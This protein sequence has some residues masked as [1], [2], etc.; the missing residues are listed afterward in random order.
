[1]KATVVVE[2][3]WDAGWCGHLEVTGSPGQD[4]SGTTIGFT[5]PTGTRITQTWNGQFSATEGRVRVGLPSW[6]R[7]PMTATGFCVAGTGAATDV[8]VG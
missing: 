6:A 1:V 5:L 3:R 7:A 4:L 2:N 8:R